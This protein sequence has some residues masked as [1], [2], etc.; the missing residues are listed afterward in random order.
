AHCYTVQTRDQTTTRTT[1]IYTPH[2]SPTPP[3]RCTTL[4]PYTTLFRSG[5]TGTAVTNLTSVAAYPNSPTSSGTLTSFEIPVNA[6]DNYG[7]RV[8][9]YNCSHVARWYAVCCARDNK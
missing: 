7:I 6:E 2:V 1:S 5:I 4:L 9:G 3:P 8:G